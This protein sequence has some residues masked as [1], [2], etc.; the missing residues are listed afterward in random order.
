[1]TLYFED[2]LRFQSEYN[3]S[4]DIFQPFYCLEIC[5]LR[6][7]YLD[8]DNEIGG[9]VMNGLAHYILISYPS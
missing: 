3:I 9:A 5:P 8:S 6:G 7:R 4:M 1:M 2:L